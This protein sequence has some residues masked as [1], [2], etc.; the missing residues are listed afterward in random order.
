MVKSSFQRSHFPS[1]PQAQEIRL[2][3]TIGYNQEKH[4][5]PIIGES[6][7]NYCFIILF[8]I[9]REMT[10]GSNGS[11]GSNIKQSDQADG[12]KMPAS[13]NSG[14]KTHQITVPI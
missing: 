6:G 5:P 10:N 2:D 7:D 3:V 13:V 8:F 9:K 1:D 14:Q 12:N 4:F 11:N